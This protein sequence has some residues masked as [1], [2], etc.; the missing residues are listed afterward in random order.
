[1]KRKIIKQGHN[2]LTM[3][4]PS[5]WVRK[6]NLEAGEE[7]DVCEN[8]GSLVIKHIFVSSSLSIS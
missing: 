1:M 4:L 2:T 3:T 6:L 7:V 5:D 8:N